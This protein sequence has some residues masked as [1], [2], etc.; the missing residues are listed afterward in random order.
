MNDPM[1]L[2]TDNDLIL[3]N[4]A[5]TPAVGDVTWLGGRLLTDT[6]E[7]IRNA[8]V[9]IWQCDASGVYLHTGDSGKKQDKQDKNFQG[10][11]R[12]TTDKTGAYYFRTI[13][14]VPYE[15]YARAIVASGVKVVE[16]AGNNPQRVLPILKD[17]G[18]KA[19]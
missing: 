9:E 17:A 14:P 4:D 7:P 1:P 2:D 3:I 16:T 10:F 15:E 6:G 11:G 18:I 13:K 5:I 8:V 12:F 19:D